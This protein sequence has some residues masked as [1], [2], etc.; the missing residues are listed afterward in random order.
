MPKHATQQGR[1]RMCQTVLVVT[2]KVY[3]CDILPSKL[4]DNGIDSNRRDDCLASAG[5]A[6]T[7]KN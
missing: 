7:S 4:F 6:W 2:L 3:D 1:D 5:I